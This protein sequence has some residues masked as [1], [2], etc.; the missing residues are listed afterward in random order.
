M[1]IYQKKK[2]KIIQ[3]NLSRNKDIEQQIDENIKNS[4]QLSII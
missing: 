2:L 3:I 1:T 4:V